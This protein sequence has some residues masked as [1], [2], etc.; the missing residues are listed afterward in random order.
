MEELVSCILSQHT[1]DRT[2]YPAFSELR[3]RYPSWSAVLALGPQALADVIR[4]AGLANQKAKS[5]CGCL[6]AIRER[7]GGFT[8]EP[9]RHMPLLEA[10]K[11]LT[12]LP[13]VGPKT[14]SIVLGFSFGMGAIPIDTHVFRVCSRLGLLAEGVTEA[15][16]HDLLLDM[17]PP[18]LATRFHV[19]L[20][21]HGRAVCRAPRPHC[22]LC[23]LTEVCR[24]FRLS[25]SA[26]KKAR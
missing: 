15:K 20:L 19:A 3:R 5:I 13:G 6:A 21:A 14:A 17:V 2:S 25:G 1:S 12:S 23:P 9:L 24:W 22:H 10:R 8:L 11:W 18:E 4:G 7:N 26:R 16:A